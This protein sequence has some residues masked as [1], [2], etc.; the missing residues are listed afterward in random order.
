MSLEM[1][2]KLTVSQEK[3]VAPTSMWQV[4]KRRT[5]PCAAS[6]RLLRF[7]LFVRSDTQRQ[8]APKDKLVEVPGDKIQDQFRVWGVYRL[9]RPKRTV[10]HDG[11]HPIIIQNMN[12]FSVFVS[13][14]KF[15]LTQTKPSVPAP[16]RPP[17]STT[18]KIMSVMGNYDDD[19][20]I[21]KDNDDNP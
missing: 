3:C 4:V 8:L 1:I 20:Y 12:V 6:P 13:R 2:M 7:F 11:P 18:L 14:S 19:D 16:S 15:T 17:T 5:S 9:L 21:D 10:P